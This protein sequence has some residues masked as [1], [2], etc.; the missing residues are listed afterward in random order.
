[1]KH[2]LI[3]AAAAATVSGTALAADHGMSS[4]FIDMEKSL[5]GTARVTANGSKLTLRINVKGLKPGLHGLHIHPIGI[6]IP[7]AY[8]EAGKHWNPLGHQH[9]KDNP[10][11]AHLGDLPNILVNKNGIGKGKFPLDGINWHGE[12]A[13]MDAD[14]FAIIIH[15]DADDYRVDPSGNSGTKIACAPFAPAH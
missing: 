15:A 12:T 4:Q 9:G 2:V 13:L 8:S 14:G 1:M 5:I 3:F 10:M 7:P 6:C 11:G